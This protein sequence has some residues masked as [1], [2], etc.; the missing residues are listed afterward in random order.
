MIQKSL[1]LSKGSYA[2]WIIKRQLSISQTDRATINGTVNGL[3]SG[4]FSST[5]F[6]FLH[7]KHTWS[8]GKESL[9][10]R[11]K[12]PDTEERIQWA[13]SGLYQRTAF[14]AMEGFKPQTVFYPNRCTPKLSFSEGSMPC[15]TG[16]H[17]LFLTQ[18]A[19]PQ[20]LVALTHHLLFG[21]PCWRCHHLKMSPCKYQQNHPIYL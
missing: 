12:L 13:Q 21:A 3:L 1:L 18:V 15:H 10:P 7:N 17:N 5:I 8:Y 6:C 20:P 9:P 19:L 14:P 2:N 11:Q 16:L 4:W